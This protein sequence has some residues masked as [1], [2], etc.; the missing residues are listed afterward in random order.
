MMTSTGPPST[1]PPLIDLNL[2]CLIHR[3]PD[4]HIAFGTKQ[5]SAWQDLFSFP[6]RLLE[7]LPADAQQ[8]LERDA[9]FSLNG[10]YRTGRGMSRAVP[11]LPRAFRQTSGLRYLNVAYT[12]LDAH[13]AG[14][15][16]TR[17][18]QDALAEV[19]K[20]QLAGELPP[21]SIV[22]RSGRGAWLLWLLA[23]DSTDADAPAIP[24]PT[25]LPSP[26]RS[27]A[28]NLR[29][30]RAI[31]SAIQRRLAH[32]G[33]DPL[34]VDAVRMARVPG[35][36][37]SGTGRPV[38]YEVQ[39]GTDGRPPIYTL[40]ELAEA[41]KVPPE[42]PREASSARSWPSHPKAGTDRKPSGWANV[43]LSRLRQLAKL[44]ELRNGFSEGC[45]NHAALLLATTL[46]GLG[47]GTAELSDRLSALAAGCR[48]PLSD[49]ECRSAIKSGTS[50]RYRF[51]NA[52][53]S[54]RLAISPAEAEQLETWGPAG[55]PHA[56]EAH[57]GSQG[58][59]I[60][61]KKDRHRLILSIL[62]QGGGVLP[63]TREMATLLKQQ[64]HQAT[65]SSVQRDYSALGLCGEGLPCP[66]P[67]I[68][69]ESSTAAA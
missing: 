55:E 64:G 11:G 41:F 67:L 32:L 13:K 1:G 38:R 40:A 5:Q 35:S 18:V 49:S 44:E 48:P 61:R 19:S 37:H 57:A 15:D 62:E 59:K 47:V 9:Y 12:D 10:M 27:T 22:V 28:G 42:E 16:A 53:I 4:S 50:G 63:S 29:T 66:T 68:P 20:M 21:P 24:L 43:N 36:V 6:G 30:Y 25:P 69:S 26:P 33:A 60:S 54:A 2:V 17:I 8:L 52:T 58:T 34:A 56:L 23:A 3:A 65:K 14:A 31:Q 7:T 46:H 45:R 51:S 39:A